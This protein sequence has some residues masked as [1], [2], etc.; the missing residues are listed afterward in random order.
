VDRA[1]ASGEALRA[2]TATVVAV[3]KSPAAFIETM[4]CLPVAA[5]PEG[6]EWTYEIKLD[7][8]R[9]EAVKTKGNVTVYSRRRNVL[10]EKFRY[11]ADALEKLPDETVL[12][13]ELVAMDEDGRSNFNLLQN[14]KS[15][16][17]KIHYFAFDVLMHKGKPL[18]DQPLE[19]R[20]A[21]L[22]KILPRNDHISLSAVG[23]SASQMLA[24]VKEHGLE[25]I[26]AKRA[27][28]VYEPGKRTGLWSKYRVNL[29]QE[30]VVGGYTAG[31]PFDALIVGFYRGRDLMF[32]GRVRAGF[33]PATRREVFAKLKGLKVDK[34]TFAN[35][36]EKEPGRWGQGLTAEKM[37]SCTWV[38]PE[39]V[40][41]I[42]FSEWTGADK[43]RHTKFVALRDDKPAR[44]VVRET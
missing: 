16:A 36:P 21:I 44:K 43:L 17:S 22:S 13:G 14:F 23:R 3:S 20:R 37:K 35:L 38:K 42:D 32:A 40:V 11:I 31:N 27:D 41:R 1:D 33:V 8:Y 30:F 39:V 34:C 6:P 2:G 7:G 26:V 10:N 9:L 5:V 24:F 12:D 15:A 28:S 25:G 18:A 19:K 4:D 29:G